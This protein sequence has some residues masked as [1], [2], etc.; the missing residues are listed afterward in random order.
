MDTKRIVDVQVGRVKGGGGRT[1][2]RAVALG[3]CVA[4]VLYDP[5]RKTG[6]MAHVM[7]PGRAP[8]QTKSS[9]RTRYAADAIDTLLQIMAKTGSRVSDLSAAVV[10]GA[11]VLRRAND[12][13]G[14]DNVE[15]SLQILRQKGLK[16]VAEDNGGYERR[17]VSIDLEKGILSCTEGDSAERELWRATACPGDI[18]L[19]TETRE[20]GNEPL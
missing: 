7:L 13:I 15:S 11:N 6:A 20:T 1:I 17:N 14:T 9:Q 3:S 16:I 4:V 2:L 12:T 5:V 19:R 8:A 18:R 10:G